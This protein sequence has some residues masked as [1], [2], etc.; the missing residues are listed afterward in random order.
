MTN[1]DAD[2]KLVAVLCADV[3]G[4][5][6]MIGEDEEGTL[7]ALAAHMTELVEPAIAGHRGRIVKTTGDG[8][9]A[10]FASPIAA[11]LRLRSRKACARATW[12]FP[13]QGSK[14]SGSA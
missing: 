14:G 9:L 7:A 8:F 11:A 6:R 5:S 2:R 3:A 1:L 12:T 4:Y 10:E 13:R